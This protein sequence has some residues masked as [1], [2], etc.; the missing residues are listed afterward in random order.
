MP[1]LKSILVMADRTADAQVALQ[2]AFVIARHFAARIELLAC[3]PEHP[4]SARGARHPEAGARAAAARRL[5][6]RR[7]LEALRSSISA[8]DLLIDNSD[9]LDG[10]LHEGLASKVR[11]SGHNLVVKRLNRREGRRRSTLGPADWQV[12]HACPVPM[13]LT[14]GRPWRPSPR[15]V[16]TLAEGAEGA[17]TAHD[18]VL[19]VAR[20]LARG[21]QG[22]LEIVEAGTAGALRAHGQGDAP[23]ARFAAPD[24]V[25]VV[26]LSA[27]GRDPG[28]RPAGAADS[29][30][31]LAERIVDTLDC[32]V[33]LL[34]SRAH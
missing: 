32:D 16:A 4:W 28:A 27:W 8:E 26:V 17:R 9:D 22:G 13:M 24:D 3:D 33:L 6:S 30:L 31:A 12:I 34:P 21:C 25:D 14:R 19:D 11:A 2:K 29:G 7:F 18:E 15:F 10:P 23:L 5:D 20:Y 1:P